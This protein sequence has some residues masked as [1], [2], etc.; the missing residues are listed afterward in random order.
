MITQEQIDKSLIKLSSLIQQIKDL[1]AVID[2]LRDEGTRELYLE[3][4][5]DVITEYNQLLTLI[6]GHITLFLG[7][8][9]SNPNLNYVR[10]LDVINSL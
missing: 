4:I 3:R 1:D 6:K 10:L 9:P 8:N 2:E 5:L 7:Q